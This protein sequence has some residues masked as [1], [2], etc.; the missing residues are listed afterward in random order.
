MAASAFFDQAI[1]LL[2]KLKSKQASVI[3]MIRCATA[4]GLLQRGIVPI[5]LPGHQFVGNAEAGK[6]LE[7]FYEAYRK[8]FAHLYE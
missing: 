2:Q 3:N 5:M 1:L 6:Q 4:E 7:L 8:S